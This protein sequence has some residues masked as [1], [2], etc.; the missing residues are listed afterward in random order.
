M[1][2]KNFLTKALTE[3]VLTRRSFLKWSTALGGTAVLAGGIG[4]GLKAV[5]AAVEEQ[6]K[7]D[8]WIPAACWHNCGGRCLIKAN[9]VDGVVKRVKTD[10]NHPDTPDYPQ[11]RGCQRGRSQRYQVFGAD[12]LKYPMKRAHWEPGGGNKE[13]RGRDEWVRIS[14]D[15][16]LT[17]IASEVKRI[18]EKYGP[19][20]IWAKTGNSLLL[21][22]GYV[23]NWGSTSTG[24]WAATGPRIGID[25]DGAFNDRF[26]LRNTKLVVMWGANP[27]WS[28][29]GLPTYNYLQVKNAGAKFI[30]VDPYYNESA[31]ALADEWI[32][33]RPGTDSALLLAMAYVMLKLD[34][35]T[36]PLID[37]DFLN[38]CTIGF[39]KDHLPEGAD[40]E[41]NFKDYV[42]GLDA[43]GNPAPKG[44]KNYPAKTAEWA[45]EITGI[46]PAQIQ[47]FT[48]EVASTKQTNLMLSWAPARI[49]N[50]Q[51]FPQIF[52]A[53]GA[54]AGFIGRSGAG[55]GP[56]AHSGASNGGPSLVTGG[57][58]GVKGVTNPLSKVTINNNELWD[59]VLTGKFTLNGKKRDINLQM[60]Y[61]NS[62][63]TLQTRVGMNK[64]IQAHRKVEFVVSHGQFLTTNAKYSDIVLPVTTEWERYGTILTGNREIL[65]WTSQIVDPLFECH[66]DSWIDVELG[67]R[68][69]LDPAKVLPLDL[70]QQT[71]NRIAGAKVMKNDGSG[72]ETLVTITDQDMA[73]LGVKGKAQTGRIPI[74]EFKQKGIY[75]VPRT[76][77]DAFTT[78]AFQDFRSDPV[79][80]PLKTKSGKIELH[81]QDLADYIN[82]LGW[83]T[84]RPI[85]VYDRPTE[86]YEDTFSDWE[87]KVK[88]EFPFQLYNIH[89]PRRSHTVFDNVPV[90]REAFPDE[91][92]MN[93]IDA[94]A[95]GLKDEDTVLITSRHGKV[96]RKLLITPRLMPGVVD[97]PHGAWVELIDDQGVDKAGADNYLNGAIPTTEG[98]MGWNSCNVKVEKWNGEPLTPD[99]KW[100]QRI[101][102]KG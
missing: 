12:R 23:S 60:L 50:A 7:E 9:V 4:Y 91:F 24:T 73:T 96:L 53:V 2:E 19:E 14:W 94:K 58:S 85:P 99:V 93:P 47:S 86:G 13:L 20:S 68:M 51:H 100:P 95:L 79:K 28:S 6:A 44:H 25:S 64:G 80:N 48:V 43:N 98:H 27:I 21:T 30:F 35:P 61:H 40:P 88:G 101:I 26:D 84:I 55:I 8:K 3:T 102:F 34:S 90:L 41:D 65:I 1:S 45:S 46:P 29:G 52:V 81:C 62:S 75:Q 38:R 74:L 83:S 15:E 72:F 57:S 17:T 32:P 11:Q 97:L 56:S 59:A 70:K 77:G 82:G 76:P 54:M 22:G 36:T 67:K 18:R 66:D 5:E 37:W 39:D 89:Y 71:F 42:L 33:I 69:G 49:N 16:A 92:F 63:A 87:K 10:D 78:I 31:V